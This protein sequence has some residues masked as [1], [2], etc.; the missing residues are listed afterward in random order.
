MI[1]VKAVPAEGTRERRLTGRLHAFEGQFL[2]FMVIRASW[3]GGNAVP[4]YR[5][6]RYYFEQPGQ[7]PRL[8]DPGPLG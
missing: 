1:A 2:P 4:A 8:A 6:L 3:L 5:A 7:R